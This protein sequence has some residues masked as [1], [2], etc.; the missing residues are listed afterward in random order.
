MKKVK[1]ISKSVHRGPYRRRSRKI[2]RRPLGK[3]I[4]IQLLNLRFIANSLNDVQGETGKALNEIS[5]VWKSVENIVE[6]MTG[7]PS[8]DSELF[9]GDRESY[10]FKNPRQTLLTSRYWNPHDRVQMPNIAV[11]FFNRLAKKYPIP[12]KLDLKKDTNGKFEIEATSHSSSYAQNVLWLLWR[13]YFHDA[14]WE[15]LK[16]CPFCKKWYAD[17]SKNKTKLYCSR[18]CHDRSWNRPRRRNAGHTG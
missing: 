12:L 15:R 10:L 8:K 2:K 16:R 17:G 13:F 18:P 11:G 6:V 1:N 9:E 14:G 7:Q 4:E 3:H 5:S